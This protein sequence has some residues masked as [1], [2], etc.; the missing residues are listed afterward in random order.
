[1]FP[2]INL[3]GVK[4]AAQELVSPRGEKKKPKKIKE[5]RKQ[6]VDTIDKSVEK[7]EPTAES[8]AAARQLFG[9][10]PTT[11]HLKKR[12]GEKAV[13]AH[14]DIYK[15][16][17]NSRIYRDNLYGSFQLL[18]EVLSKEEENFILEHKI[19]PDEALRVFGNPKTTQELGETYT[20]ILKYFARQGTKESFEPY[21]NNA[22]DIARQK[23]QHDDIP[24][25]V[26]AEASEKMR[27]PISSNSRIASDALKVLGLHSDAFFGK[28]L[29]EQRK[30]IQSARNG[31]ALALHPDKHPNGGKLDLDAD[32]SMARFHGKTP[33]EAMKDLNSAYDALSAFI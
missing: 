5:E 31:L 16:S 6:A 27:E 20:E 8:I 17:V 13:G 15:I 32:T 19:S 22:F 9:D 23:I 11:Y 26:A 33:V 21:F 2:R 24:S 30:D 1:M 18:L 14:D 4:K 28:S 7:T 25:P 10:P 29:D 12:Y 3:K